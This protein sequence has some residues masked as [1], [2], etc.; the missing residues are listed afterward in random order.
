MGGIA[1]KLERDAGD[2]LRLGDAPLLMVGGAMAVVGGLTS[3]VGNVLHPRSTDYYDDPVAWLD[4]N[5][6]SDIWFPSHLLILVGSIIFV[7]GFVALSRSL[8][9]TR[10]HGIGNLG[11]ANALI[12]TALIV[13]CLVIDG[14]VVHELADVWSAE[15]DPSPDSVLTGT[16]LY[17]TIFNFLYA[18]QMTLFGLAPIF[19]GIA[20]LLTGRYARWFSWIGI[21]AG[22]TVFVSA[23]LSMVDVNRKTLDASVWP[24]TAT[25][26]VLWFATIGGLLWRRGANAG[27]E[28]A[29]A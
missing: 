26:V 9:G 29:P 13:V 23:V 8:V 7:G 6:D 2:A 4:H 16:I 18:F 17:Y 22:A 5:T 15:G 1:T 21:V 19:Y 24:V 20:T 27:D 14:P 10:G 3:L 11:L 12:G 25:V 28:V